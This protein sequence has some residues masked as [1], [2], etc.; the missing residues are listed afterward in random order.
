VPVLHTYFH[1][2]IPKAR[3][4]NRRFV[5]YQ[6]EYA[7]AKVGSKLCHAYMA[8]AVATWEYTKDQLRLWHDAGIPQATQV[9]CRVVSCRVVSCRVVS[10][11]VVSCRVVSCRVV[12]CRV[13]SCRDGL[14]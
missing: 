5:A 2:E 10:C 14:C 9:S 11:R 8:G 13:V 1:Y 4:R 3:S 6:L 7:E 12:S